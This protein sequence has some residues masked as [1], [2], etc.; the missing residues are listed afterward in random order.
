M[1]KVHLLS[2]LVLKNCVWCRGKVLKT[3]FLLSELQELRELTKLKK[4]GYNA[5]FHVR[6]DELNMGMTES[7]KEELK[8]AS[9]RPKKRIDALLQEAASV[10]ASEKGNVTLINALALQF[11]LIH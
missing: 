6:Q 2:R 11:C 7:S 10:G 1:F 8:A 4:E 3:Y 5:S 9:G